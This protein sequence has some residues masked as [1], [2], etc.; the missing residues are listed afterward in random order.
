MG[1]KLLKS[2]NLAL[3]A[4]QGWRLQMAHNSLVYRVYKAKYFKDCDFIQATLGN[5]PSYVWRSILTART[6][7]GR[8][9]DGEWEMG[10][11]NM[12]ES[13]A[14]ELFLF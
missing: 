2:F 8:V 12:G 14:V 13:M 6:L 7:L 4:K 9:F 5:N 3:L 10:G 1:L 11:V